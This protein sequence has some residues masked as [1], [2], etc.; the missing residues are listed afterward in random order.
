MRP[1]IEEYMLEI[2]H[3]AKTR[4]TCVRRSVGCVITDKNNHILSTGYNGVPKGA[5]HCTDRNCEGAGFKSTQGLDSCNAIHAEINAITHC[6]SLDKAHKLYTTTSPCMS[7]IKTI[8]ATQIREIYFVELYD[9]E[10]LNLFAENGG[11]AYKAVIN[12]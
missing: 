2:A 11:K 10:A 1:T 4:S 9:A 3:V 8:L 5:A 6:Y 12:I 7:C